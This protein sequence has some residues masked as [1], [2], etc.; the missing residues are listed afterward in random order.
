M[1]LCIH[2]NTQDQKFCP[3]CV[4]LFQRTVR[5]VERKQ[6]TVRPMYAYFGSDEGMVR[7]ATET[8]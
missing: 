7:K 5:R 2:Q 4:L 8:A 6:V 1:C 3:V